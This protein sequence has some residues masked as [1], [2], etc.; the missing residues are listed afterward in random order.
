M[1][2]GVS[3]WFNDFSESDPIEAT[4]TTLATATADTTS[5]PFAGIT[6]GSITFSSTEQ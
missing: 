5:G 4:Q 6:A 3:E 2:N 1:I